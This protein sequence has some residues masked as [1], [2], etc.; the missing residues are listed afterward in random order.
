MQ[1][2]LTPV[3]GSGHRGRGLSGPAPAG[4]SSSE[5]SSAPGHQSAAALPPVHYHQ[6]SDHTASAGW[7]LLIKLSRMSKCVV[8][9]RY[10][11][12]VHMYNGFASLS[13][14]LA[15]MHNQW[16]LPFHVTDFRSMVWTTKTQWQ[17]PCTLPELILHIWPYLYTQKSDS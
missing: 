9:F 16:C 12:N 13:Q 17:L 8:S 10:H 2:P 6:V 5:P 4:A 3:P 7:F 14:S 11:F 1:E 15:Q